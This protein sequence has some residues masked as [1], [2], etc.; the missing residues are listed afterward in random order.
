ME[1][2]SDGFSREVDIFDLA[3][4]DAEDSA[5]AEGDHDDMTR[6][7]FE[8]GG[9]RQRTAAAAINFRRNYLE[10]HR[11]IIAQWYNGSME[12]V[13]L[14]EKEFASTG[15][16]CGNFL[17]SVE[18]YRRYR[19]LGRE[20]YLV[21]VKLAEV[22]ATGAQ[23]AGAKAGAAKKGKKKPVIVAAGLILGRNWHFGKKIYRVPGGWLMDYE[24]EGWREVLK[25]LTE[26]AKG[27]C[28]KRG[29]MVLEIAPNIVSQTRDGEN[30]IVAGPEHLGVKRELQKLGYKYL[31][32][33]EQSKW[34]YVKD[35]GAETP[36]EMLKKFRTT[37]RQLIQKLQ[38]E[39][40][41]V[42]ELGV[43]ELGILKKIAAEAGARHGFQDPAVEYYRSMKEAFHEK[44][45]FV[46]AEIPR[47]NMRE[48]DQEKYAEEGE[49]VPLAA[50]MF[51]DDGREM[52][53]LYSGS[54]R[55]LQRYNGAYAIQWRMINEALEKGL[56]RYNFYGVKPVAGNGVY[57]FK[58][59]FR[60]RVEELLGTFVLPI[61]V[62]GKIYTG[63]LKPSE[64]GEIH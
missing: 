14:T 35:L 49:Y 43:E 10:K 11:V 16:S 31:G 32:E 45:K 37:H 58:Q 2:A 25:F 22:K 27:F 57:S 28:R 46:V 29:G 54:R 7:E 34:V 51:V 50:S 56:K 48:Q 41:R 4:D 33:Y 53:Y 30:R 3:E 63:R 52:V 47:E 15:F 17:Q 26:E 20:A 36:E 62:M 44:V 12:F 23:V 59:G 42:R 6:E 39:G 8:V 60:G 19:K 21:G 5:V 13:E 9:I 24:A 18:M 61:G 38:R 1:K 55:E 64:Y 40:V